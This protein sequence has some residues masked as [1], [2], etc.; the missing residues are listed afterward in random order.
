[1]QHP[2]VALTWVVNRCGPSVVGCQEVL[3]VSRG[4]FHGL[5][6]ILQEVWHSLIAKF[7]CVRWA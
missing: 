2:F 5:A 7:S 4:A 6:H 1:M 3:V